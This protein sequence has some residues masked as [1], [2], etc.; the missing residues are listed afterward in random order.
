M[1]LR[2]K[3][4][5]DITILS[6]VEENTHYKNWKMSNRLS[7]M[8][9]KMSIAN[10][11]KTTLPKIDNAKETLKFVEERFQTA[12]KFVVGTIMSTLTTMKFVGSR[13]MHEQVIEMTNL[14]VRLK[15]LLGMEV[16]EKFLVQFILNSLPSKYGPFQ[17]N[18]DTMKGK[19]NVHELHN[20]LV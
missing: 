18:Y 6:T 12:D 14:L 1:A 19:W 4:P 5:A 13:T 2:V 15:T 17:V 10:N 16:D 11:I 7:M 20:M 9:M 3:K 8:Y